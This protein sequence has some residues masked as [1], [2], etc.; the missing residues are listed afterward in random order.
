M[1]HRKTL[2]QY[3]PD[4]PVFFSRA[5]G[6]S[7][8]LNTLALKQL[9]KQGFDFDTEIKGGLIYKDADGPT[10]VLSDQAHIKALLM[11]PEFTQQQVE[12]FCL[13]AMLYFNRAGVTHLRDLSMNSLIWKT[14]CKLQ[15]ENQQTLCIDS[16]FTAESVQDLNRAYADLVECEKNPNP[17]L[18]AHGLKIFVDGSLGSKTAYLSQNYKGLNHSGLISWTQDQIAEAI[19]FCWSQNRSIAVH[20]IGD[21]A[22][23]VVATAARAVSAAGLEGKIHLEHVQLLR[24]ETLGL[25]KSLHVTVHMQPCHWLSDHV[26]VEQTLPEPL[27]A[28][29]FQWQ[30]IIKNKIP[31]FFGSDSPIEP[32]SLFKTR[33]ALE[34]RSKIRIPKIETNWMLNHSHPDQQWTKSVTR[35]DQNQ[36]LEVI[37]DSR[38]II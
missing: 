20:T 27:M 33:A 30:K 5:D 14:L 29:L 11:L 25:L 16:F 10:G 36:I 15:R 17:Y 38:K 4:R 37:F 34:L 26:W 9:E 7:S 28:Y 19:R 6:H 21:Q 8:W 35:F 3:F 12:K 1:P 31:L 18:R 24:P 2:D 22:V 23:H 13:A 32:S